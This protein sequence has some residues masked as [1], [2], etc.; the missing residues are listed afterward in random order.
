M[1]IKVEQIDPPV[2]KTVLASAIVNI[3]EGLVALRRSG[4]NE[5]AIIVLLS[6]R[7]RVSKSICKVVLA[8]LADLRRAYTV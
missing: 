3:S 6:D 2:G 7:T 5:D 8:G 1:K 4:L